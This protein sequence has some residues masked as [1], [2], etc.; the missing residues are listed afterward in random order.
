MVELSGNV[1]LA[2][3][4]GM[5]HEIF[6][7][8]AGNVARERVIREDPEADANFTLFVRSLRRLIELLRARDGEGAYKHWCKNIATSRAMLAVSDNSRVRDLMI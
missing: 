4:A 5:L 2:L 7:R 3:I 6:E 1:T 8:H